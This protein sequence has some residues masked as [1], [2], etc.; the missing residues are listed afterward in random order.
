MKQPLQTKAILQFNT[1]EGV[2][3]IIQKLATC[4]ILR[5]SSAASYV[6]SKR[7][8]IEIWKINN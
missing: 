7:N 6:E 8:L 4:F 1:K 3:L 5:L 2:H